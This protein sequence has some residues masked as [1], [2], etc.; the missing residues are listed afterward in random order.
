MDK[1]IRGETMIYAI[2]YA[3]KKFFNAQKLNSQTAKKFGAD[4]VIE[5]NQNSI[6]NSFYNDN[7][8]ILECRRG[9][10]YWLWKPYIINKTLPYLIFISAISSTT[11]LL[12]VRVVPKLTTSS[13]EYLNPDN[14]I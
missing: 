13:R 1:D 4:V 7:H 6:D 3:N 2:N 11:I 9:D 12:I 14:V 10:G 5:Y 8:T